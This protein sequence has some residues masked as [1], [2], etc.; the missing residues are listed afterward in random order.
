MKVI[1]TLGLFAALAAVWFFFQP[2]D[3][4]QG[5]IEP[6]SAFNRAEQETESADDP[7]DALF[8]VDSLRMRAT[9][10]E[11]ES[12]AQ[13]PLT[14]A[15]G[16]TTKPTLKSTG[17]VGDGTLVVRVIGS[18]TQDSEVAVSFGSEALWEG[19]VD[20]TSLVRI[21]L[22]ATSA[23]TGYAQL[24]GIQPGVWSVG[25]RDSAGTEFWAYQ[26]IL[27][28]PA[29]SELVIKSGNSGVYGVIYAPDG[30][31]WPDVRVLVEFQKRGEGERTAYRRATTDA[32][33]RYEI[34]GLVAGYGRIT[35]KLP[36]A[37]LPG[38]F[39]RDRVFSDR[40]SMKENEQVERSFGST[41]PSASVTL[42]VRNAAGQQIRGGF[43]LLRHRPQNEEE[44]QRPQ[45]YVNLDESGTGAAM[46][47]PA[48]WYP[49]VFADDGRHLNIDPI[50]VPVGG[51]H[52]FEI[53]LPRGSSID[54]TLLTSS[55]EAFLDITAKDRVQL[56]GGPNPRANPSTSLREDGTFRFNEIAPGTY[57]IAMYKIDPKLR[58][59]IVVQEGSPV[60]YP[61]TIKAT[62]K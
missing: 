27:A 4:V 43:V 60:V 41:L 39:D 13:E 5:G 28:G 55:G 54:G 62:R 10:E 25:V 14:A 12:M 26:R 22:E 46:I 11:P 51:S 24:D 52:V 37:E 29:I 30:R 61:V 1:A 9:I 45:L 20:W 38:E 53:V 19:T 17:R 16:A 48:L 56:L 2:A 31:P 6:F 33:G 44:A 8:R 40:I 36:L 50:E 34:N 32:E 42:R 58:V 57:S 7:V 21:P 15:T 35:A 59:E 47:Q 49:V 23:T 3:S 18:N